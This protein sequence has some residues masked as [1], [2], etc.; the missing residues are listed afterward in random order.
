MDRIYIFQFEKGYDRRTVYVFLK[1]DIE[2]WHGT[3]DKMWA[4]VQQNDMLETLDQQM[5][6]FYELLADQ[7]FDIFHSST[8]KIL[9]SKRKA[10]DARSS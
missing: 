1:V 9:T 10:A 6:A 7:G 4:F 5:E 8:K 3:I 2:F